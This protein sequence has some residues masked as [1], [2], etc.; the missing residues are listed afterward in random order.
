M[1]QVT[2]HYGSSHSLCIL[3]CTVSGYQIWVLWLLWCTQCT[4]CS[5]TQTRD[6]SNLWEIDVWCMWCCSNKCTMIL[7]GS[8]VIPFDTSSQININHVY[9]FWNTALRISGTQDFLTGAPDCLFWSWNQEMIPVSL[10]WHG[11][12]PLESAPFGWIPKVRIRCMPP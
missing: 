3:I 10:P 5:E 7:T 11:P 9:I 2:G 1:H 6:P 12:H 8:K 4:R